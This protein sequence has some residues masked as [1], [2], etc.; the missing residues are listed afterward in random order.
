MC[1]V[2]SN[3]EQ[4]ETS[5]GPSEKCQSAFTMYY[6]NKYAKITNIEMADMS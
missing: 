3:G 4:H 2:S 5:Y 6:N 1:A